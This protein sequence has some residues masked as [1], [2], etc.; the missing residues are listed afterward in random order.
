[1]FQK[2]VLPYLKKI[3]ELA[4]SHGLPVMLHSCGAIAKVIPILI[5]IGIDALH[6][7]Q[8]RARGMD[9]ET[10]AK[11]FRGK[12]TFVGGVD[13]QDLLVNGSP[14]DVRREVLRLR[15]TFKERYIVSPS[16]EAVLPNVP[17]ENIEAMAKAA[18]EPL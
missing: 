11:N 18:F 9:A 15:K 16:H 7:L 13:T 12:L 6:P 17:F 14:D 4:K 5:D 2:F 8:A 1:M 3:V 10:L